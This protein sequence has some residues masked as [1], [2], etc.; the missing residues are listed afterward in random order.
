M[1]RVCIPLAQVNLGPKGAVARFVE[2]G[3][4]DDVE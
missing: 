3:I 2:P 4:V 1:D